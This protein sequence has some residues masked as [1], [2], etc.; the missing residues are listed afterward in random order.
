MARPAELRNLQTLV[1][2]AVDKNSTV[3][4]PAPLMSTIGELGSFLARGK[5]APGEP[6]ATSTGPTHSEDG[7]L[8]TS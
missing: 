8:A 2:V 6:Q 7:A 4:F 5:Q 1:E 3:V